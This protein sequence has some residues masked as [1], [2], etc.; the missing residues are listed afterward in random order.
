MRHFIDEPDSKKLSHQYSSPIAKNRILP[1][2]TSPFDQVSEIQTE[3]LQL[4]ND[5]SSFR[6]KHFVDIEERQLTSRSE[7]GTEVPN[8]PKSFKDDPNQNHSEINV[9]LKNQ[10]KGENNLEEDLQSKEKN[11][12][13]NRDLL[14][15]KT[16][17]NLAPIE[18]KT[19]KKVFYHN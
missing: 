12:A 6:L 18:K 17:T 19:G 3:K 7:S 11:E 9:L 4:K 8:S 13:L 15:R 10:V 16:K 2:A 5:K 1:L 14:V